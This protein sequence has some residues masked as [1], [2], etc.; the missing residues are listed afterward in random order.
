MVDEV[1]EETHIDQF[2]VSR[3][4]DLNLQ[5]KEKPLA[6]FKKGINIL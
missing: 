6:D 2:F 3:S 4:V 5:V 1:G